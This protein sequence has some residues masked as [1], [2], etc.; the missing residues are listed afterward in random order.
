MA[1]EVNNIKDIFKIIFPDSLEA[2]AVV[3]DSQN[4]GSILPLITPFQFRKVELRP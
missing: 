3:K 4:P 1:A 2:N